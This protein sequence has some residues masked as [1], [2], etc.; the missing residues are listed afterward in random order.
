M[1]FRKVFQKD[2]TPQYR[3]IM[4]YGTNYR[5]KSLSGC[6]VSRYKPGTFRKYATLIAEPAT[7]L[8]F[9]VEVIGPAP[10]AVENFLSIY[11]QQ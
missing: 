3:V 9:S 8:R 5:V 7:W 6:T 2:L 4:K 10:H 1:L 11:K